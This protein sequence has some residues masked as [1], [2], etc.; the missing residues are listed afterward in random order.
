MQFHE[1]L[2]NEKLT[3]PRIK[4]GSLKIELNSELPILSTQPAYRARLAFNSLFRG[5][6]IKTTVAK[7]S[8]RKNLTFHFEG[9]NDSE[10][11]R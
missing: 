1:N 4:V 3:L 7:S 11:V 8:S 2:N 5:S 9:L 10:L 6:L